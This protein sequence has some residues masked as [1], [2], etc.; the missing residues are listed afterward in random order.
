MR[1]L[2]IAVPGPL[3]GPRAAYGEVIRAAVAGFATAPELDLR[4]LDDQAQPALA[5]RVAAAIVE[6]GADVV[7]GHFNSDCARAAI[8]IYRAAGIPLLLPASTAP[9]LAD[10]QGVFRLCADES[11]QVDAMAVL[12]R[13]ELGDRKPSVWSDGSAYARRLRLQLEAAVGRVLD[14]APPPDEPAMGANCAVVYLGAHVAV[15]A[16]LHQEGSNWSGVAVCCDDCAI[17]DFK[18]Q[19]R[20]GTWIC[21][22]HRHYGQLLEEAVRVAH[23]VLLLRA[24]RWN[25]VFD[26]HGEHRAAAWHLSRTEK[27]C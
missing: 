5:V 19:V 20:S 18:L 12:L 14:D 23:R 22:P 16:R 7:I 10:G 25:E 13:N 21:T 8:P 6:G 11:R 4:L 17:D 24:S 15:R 2:R 1:R 9:G 26:A 27:E 3:T